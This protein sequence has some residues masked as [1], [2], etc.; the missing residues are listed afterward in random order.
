MTTRIGLIADNHSRQADGS[1]VP[2]EVLA[3]FVGVDLIVHCGDAGTWGTLDRLQTIAP[4]VA[5]E[6]GYNGSAADAR[7][8]GVT[9]VETIEGLRV[10]IVHDLV[11][12]GVASEMSKEIRFNGS[13][14]DGLRKLFGQE[15][16]VLLYAGTHKPQIAS[17]AGVFLVNPGSP[18]LADGR[19]PG[20]LG[21]VAVLEL[22]DGIASARVV[23]LAG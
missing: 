15:I 10:G 18:T 17:A 2:A 11:R 14:R 5:V 4:V 22:A 8:A 16:D 7:V 13:P 19:G 12:H 3:A 20:K 1:D 23:D 21:H 6:G 9:R